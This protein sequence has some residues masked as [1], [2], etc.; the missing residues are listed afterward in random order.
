MATTDAPFVLDD[1]NAIIDILQQDP[2][3]VEWSLDAL[4]RHDQARVNPII[5][6]EICYQKTSAE[7]A[8]KIL[9]SLGLG[10]AELPR[11]TLYLASQAFRHYRQS[12]GKKTAPP[13]VF[14][15]GAHAA[16]LGVPIITRDPS[17]YQTHFPTVALDSP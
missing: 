2:L 6:A 5:Y 7:E 4:S 8:D 13:P 15:I 3:W 1:S 12:G 11:Q 10:Y 16:T 14:F 17:R 9:E